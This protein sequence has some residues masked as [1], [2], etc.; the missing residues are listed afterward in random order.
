MTLRLGDRQK[1]RLGLMA[2]HFGTSRQE[3]IIRALDEFLVRHTPGTTAAN[4]GCLGATGE[5]DGASDGKR[6]CAER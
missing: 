3:L 6:C 2:A 1:L 4:C 5:S